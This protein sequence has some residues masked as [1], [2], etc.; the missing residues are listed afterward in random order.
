LWDALSAASL[1][2]LRAA[3]ESSI[4]TYASALRGFERFCGLMAVVFPPA[5][6]LG[7]QSFLRYLVF[8]I[9][10]KS[11]KFASVRAAV[12]GVGDFY[13]SSFVPSP[14]SDS[15][16]SF[17]VSRLSLWCKV[18]RPVARAKVVPND[19]IAAVFLASSI[20]DPRFLV[21]AL[22]LLTAVRP[23]S[24]LAL[25]TRD[26]SFEGDI[27]KVS[28]RKVKYRKG[29]IVLR[30]YR[31]DDPLWKGWATVLWRRLL[32]LRPGDLI[33]AGWT[34]RKVSKAVRDLCEEAGMIVSADE[35]GACV[36]SRSLRR[37]RA[38]LCRDQGEDE[39]EIAYLLMHTCVTSQAPY[40]QGTSP[41][42]R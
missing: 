14:C 24:L 32:W 8:L 28:W 10:V 29:E 20:S 21:F 6:E 1:L 26:I 5:G 18:F 33:F 23:S 2:L 9:A 13:K 35:D 39:E 41:H 40:L 31:K 3:V 37:T 30:E 11:Q 19:I 27:V 25:R 15:R 16:V 38:Q 7:V 22:L 4:V 36:S 42:A 12:A 17:L 34:S